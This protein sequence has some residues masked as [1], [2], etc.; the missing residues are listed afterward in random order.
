[1]PNL[2][3][4]KGIPMCYI[5]G[6]SFKTLKPLKPKSTAVCTSTGDLV[7]SRGVHR[8]PYCRG[9]SLKGRSALGDLWRPPEGPGGSGH[10]QGLL[11]VDPEF[12]GSPYKPKKNFRIFSKIRISWIRIRISGSA[13]MPLRWGPK[14]LPVAKISDL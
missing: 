2:T 6:H 14:G 4:F 3:K 11:G 1:M 5:Y 8:H 13:S 10:Y 9:S 7:G 12:K